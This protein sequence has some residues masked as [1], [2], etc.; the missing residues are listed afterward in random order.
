MA[1]NRLII[2]FLRGLKNKPICI[3]LLTLL[4]ALNVKAQESQQ[5][6]ITGLVKDEFNAPLIGVS[7]KKCS[8]KNYH[9]Y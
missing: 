9:S 4:F 1:L 6:Q 3:C 5:L 8:C 2:K 7:I